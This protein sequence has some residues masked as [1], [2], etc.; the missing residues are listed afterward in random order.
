MPIGD[1]AQTRI[2]RLMMETEVPPNTELS[3][4][5]YNDITGFRYI[6][7]FV[8]YIHEDPAEPPLD[9]SVEFA[10][11]EKG[12]MTTRRHAIV[13]NR[14]LSSE[15]QTLSPVTVVGPESDGTPNQVV[16]Y[17]LRVPIMGP[18]IEV[19]TNNRASVKRKVT[20]WGYLIA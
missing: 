16:T 20:V 19:F 14:T 18:F 3:V 7:L 4:P 8:R 13:E 5:P 15:P 11:D 1:L 10:F 9:L 2:L 6:N 17:V 12:L